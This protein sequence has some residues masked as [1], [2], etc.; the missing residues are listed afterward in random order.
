MKYKTK[1]DVDID[2]VVVCEILFSLSLPVLVVVSIK[3]QNSAASFALIPIVEA[4]VTVCFS[5]WFQVQQAGSMKLV[6]RGCAQESFYTR[7]KELFHKLAGI[8]G[9]LLYRIVG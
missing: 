2:K 3:G 6:C 5:G 7:R 1:L 4:A 8:Y 9:S